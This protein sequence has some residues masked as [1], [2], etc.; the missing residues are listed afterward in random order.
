M[1]IVAS[2]KIARHAGCE[3]TRAPFC[4]SF[5]VLPSPSALIRLHRDAIF[6]ALALREMLVR[7]SRHFANAVLPYAR[8]TKRDKEI[9]RLNRRWRQKRVRRPR[10]FAQSAPIKLAWIR[11][12]LRLSRERR[13]VAFLLHNSGRDPRNVGDR[14]R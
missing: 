11:W 8:L 3:P 4:F 7:Y 2:T 10:K 14:Y 1:R 12:W 13:P 9:R 5:V 6:V